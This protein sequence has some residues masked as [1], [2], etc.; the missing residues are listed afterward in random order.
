MIKQRYFSLTLI[1]L[2]L[3]FTVMQANAQNTNIIRGKVTSKE[4]GKPLQGITVV[5]K[6]RND[7][8]IN[9]VPTDINGNFQIQI[10]DKSDSLY[11]SQVG[12]KTEAR[13]IRGQVRIN[14]IMAQ[15]AKDLGTVIVVGR[16]APVS[17]TGGFLDLDKRMLS[18]AITTVKMKDLE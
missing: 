3:C 5:E 10:T 13:A 12:L 6:D 16:R 11:F 4:T 15:D 1:M 7:R 9:G 2:G 8:I 17:S 18:S 14:V